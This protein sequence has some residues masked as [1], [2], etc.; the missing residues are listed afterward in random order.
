MARQQERLPADRFTHMVVAPDDA[1]QRRRAA[2]ERR[3]GTRQRLVGAVAAGFARG[4]VD[5][6]AGVPVAGA[7][8]GPMQLQHRIGVGQAGRLLGRDHQQQVREIRHAAHRPVEP[9]AEIEHARSC[10][11][12]RRRAARRAAAPARSARSRRARRSRTGRPG[13]RT[14]RRACSNASGS[15]SRPATTAPRSATGVRPSWMSTLASPRSPSNSSTRWPA[16][17]S[18]WLSADREPGL[19]DARPCRTRWR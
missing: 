10:S 17:A 16:R 19:A 3:T 5:D 14:R 18:A 13:C 15:G 7:G 2:E 9:G 12:G 8:L 11:R 1:G 4:H 6:D